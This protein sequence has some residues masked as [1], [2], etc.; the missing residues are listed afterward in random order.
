[1]ALEN[2]R[3]LDVT[4]RATKT[5]LPRHGPVPN[6]KVMKQIAL[7]AQLG[8]FYPFLIVMAPVV[9]LAAI[10]IQW[11]LLLIGAAVYRMEAVPD[12]ACR[13]LTTTVGNR[14]IID[15]AIDS[16][17]QISCLP[18]CSV[19]LSLLALGAE[20]GWLKCVS[21]IRNHVSLFQNF[22]SRPSEVRR[23]LLLHGH[24]A[25]S[26][27][28]LASLAPQPGYTFV[29]DDH[30]QRWAYVLSH[31]ARDFRIVQHG[32][33]DEELL[34]PNVG[35]CVNCV[36]L[37]DS[38]FRESFERYYAIKNHRLFSPKASFAYTP[39]S[40]EALLLASSFPWI[41]E[42]IRLLE[43]VR[44]SCGDIP[45]IIKFHPA[46]RYDARRDKLAAYA[47]LIYEGSGNP[48]CKIFV[49]YESF[50]EF[51]YR[52]N[53]VATVSI[54]RS[55]SVEAAA[56]EIQFL[57]TNSNSSEAGSEQSAQPL[58]FFLPESR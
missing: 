39:L 21:I 7:K 17:C 49:S 38:L 4:Y 22:L 12:R 1:M 26:L 52:R 6:F 32:F 48:G 34:L 19:R 51:D 56:D 16:D 3:V 13:I 25:L 5:D 36:Y 27:L 31:T 24:D 37:R 42:E 55:K 35:G 14:T 10:P 43:T 54:A 44:E 29:T 57:L 46:H 23:D 28:G 58:P 9:V 30:Y 8:R 33:L 18:R 45:I 11:V 47:N 20:L 2:E 41:E 40:N 53:G 50:M 15:A